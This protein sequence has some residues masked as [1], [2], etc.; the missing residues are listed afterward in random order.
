MD[1][2]Q[3]EASRLAVQPENVVALAN[4]ARAV[5]NRGISKAIASAPTDDMASAMLRGIYG[6]VLQIAE[7]GERAAEQAAMAAE[8]LTTALARARGQDPAAAKPAFN[9]LFQQF[10]SP[11]SYDPRKFVAAMKKVESATRR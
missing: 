7:R 8:T 3:I 5:V 6:D 9:E 2:L 1:K 10:E 11:S 4:D